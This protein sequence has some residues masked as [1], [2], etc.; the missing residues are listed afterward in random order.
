MH[1]NMSEQIHIDEKVTIGS[2]SERGDRLTSS[3]ACVFRNLKILDATSVQG[4]PEV[5]LAHK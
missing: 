4:P 2:K 5:H 1:L 3:E